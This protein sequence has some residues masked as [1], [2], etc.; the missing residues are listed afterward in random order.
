MTKVQ[1]AFRYLL[2]LLNDVYGT[3][4]EHSEALEDAAIEFRLNKHEIKQLQSDYAQQ[5]STQQSRN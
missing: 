1:K 3:G 5:L 2:D 4:W